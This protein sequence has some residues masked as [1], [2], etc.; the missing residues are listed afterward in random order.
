MGFEK[1][2]LQR[3]GIAAECAQ[4]S[5]H[6]CDPQSVFLGS[7]AAILM[8]LSPAVSPHGLN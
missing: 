2:K 7:R 4:G 8:V 6:S 3:A 1:I 5:D